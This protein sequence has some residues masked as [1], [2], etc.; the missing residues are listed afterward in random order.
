MVLAAF[1]GDLATFPA[2]AASPAAR[3]RL[4][5]AVVK[6]CRLA[7]GAP[8]PPEAAQQ[9]SGLTQNLLAYSD[10]E[11]RLRLAEDLAEASWP[12]EGL[13]R[14]LAVGP[15]DSAA[16]ILRSSPVLGRCDLIDLIGATGPEHHIEIARR[17]DL[18]GPAIDRLIH[19]RDGAVLTALAENPRLDLEGRQLQALITAARTTAAL[20]SPLAHH[21]QL[22]ES[23]AY[24]LYPWCDLALRGGL[25]ARFGLKTA[26]LDSA[27]AQ[28][29]PARLEDDLAVGAQMAKL[30]AAGQLTSGHLVRALMEGHLAAFVQGLACLGDLPLPRLRA[31]LDG[32]GAESLALACRS[33]GMDRT[34]FPQVLSLVRGLNRGRPMGSVEDA[35]RVD[36]AFGGVSP[37]WAARAFSLLP[38]NP[39]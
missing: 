18:P 19:L 5:M 27:L 25:A 17:S 32:P 12:G 36:Q 31:A 7:Q 3:D 4:V 39:I 6:L 1:S 35:E 2:D 38:L 16:P 11:T 24:G 26:A 10:P 13:I 21:R 8:V 22:T 28:S 9:V 29:D 14:T 33:V 37:L 15:I 34:V 23:L 30:H 20:R